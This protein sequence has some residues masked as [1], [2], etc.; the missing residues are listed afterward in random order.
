VLVEGLDYRFGF[1]STSN[2][3][4]LTPLAGVWE[5]ESVYQIRFINT[6]ESSIQIV[7]PKS[8]VDGTIY[9]I[10]DSLNASSRFE[11]D[12]GV[13]LRLP[14][15]IDGLNSTAVEGR[16]FRIDDGFRRVTF[17]FDNNQNV[18]SGNVQIPINDQESPE[19]LAERIASVIR[20][21]ALSVSVKSIGNG[22]LQMLGSN[23]V[24][25]VA[26]D[27]SIVATG[28]SGTTPAYGLQIPTENGLPVGVLD[29]QTF[30]IQRGNTTVVFEL[31]SNGTVAATSVRVPLSTTSTDGLAASIVTAING[32]NMGLTATSTPG[33]MIAVGTQSDLRIQA[34]N[35]VLRVVGTP[36]SVATTAVPIDLATVLTSE[37]AATLLLNKIAAANLPGVQLTQLASRI[38]IEGAKGVA[39]L[40]ATAVSGIR[41]LAGNAM[42][43]TEIDGK[44]VLTIFLGEGLDYGDAADPL[45]ASKKAN[46][47]AR[48]TVVNGYSLGPTVTSDADARL[49][50]LDTDDGV[51]IQPMT[52]AFTGSIIVNVQG[53]TVARPAFISAWVDYNGNGTFES[54][55]KIAI[56]GRIANGDN[57]L[58]FGIP[59]TAKVNTPVAMRVRLSSQDNLLPTGLAPDGEVED[60]YVTLRA[61][62]YT[63]AT[64]ALD[65]NGDGS[66]S[67]IDVLQLVNYL[68]F[69]GSGPLPFPTTLST[70]PYLDVNGDGYITPLDVLTVINYI[71]ARTN[72]GGGEGEGSGNTWIAASGS[73][74]AAPSVAAP[75]VAGSNG[76]TVSSVAAPSNSA[77]SKLRS[78]DEYLAQVS[79]VMGP[80]LELDDLDW[81]A[82][83]PTVEE[84][85]KSNS[86]LSLAL[87]D[88]L[89]EL[90]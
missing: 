59:G 12:T 86:D 69:N 33:G 44:T 67:P 76:S 72:G 24:T 71:N 14:S 57:A 7:D 18:R 19:V 52:A 8:I 43:A 48:H 78:L 89:A 60:Y 84:E 25:F 38:L 29:G 46:N 79:T 22:E 47:G 75:A 6:N 58:T 51:T 83:M 17:E 32:A 13:R 5:T 82:V 35:T 61:N 26:E 45:Y 68:N 11:L 77:S 54:T 66:V 87:D 74:V 40:G 73:T 65:V 4:R 16:I 64:N 34:T 15:S 90:L 21:T 55:E 56:A 49:I 81:S 1:D 53:A 50:D 70:P 27:S 23:L 41:D 39:G 3:V 63:N 2:I 9:T 30:T 42:R 85:A 10:L 37:Q 88:I 36:G 80:S 31:D 20:N 28:K 62:P